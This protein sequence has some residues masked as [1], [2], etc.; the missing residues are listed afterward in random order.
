RHDGALLYA[1]RRDDQVK[2]RGV[3]IEL[4]EVEA[5]IRQHV[6]GLADVVA[7]VRGKGEG[8]RLCA[9]VVAREGVAFDV[10]SAAAQLEGKVPASLTPTAWA[11]IVPVPHCPSGKVDRRDLPEPSAKAAT[12]ETIQEPRSRDAMLLAHAFAR[13]TG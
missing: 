9:W 4:G 3:R 2:V 5:G 1:G 12:L 11:I 13:A 6:A 7:A 8:T 10:E